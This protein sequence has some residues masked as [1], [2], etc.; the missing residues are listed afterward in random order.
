MA[1]LTSANSVL[2]LGVQNLFNT[3]VQIQGFAADDAFLTQDVETSEVLMGI[4]GQMSYGYVPYITMFEITLQA[5]SASNAFFDAILNA[6]RFM[7]DDLQINGSLRLP[8]L[9]FDYSMTNGVLQKA[10]VVPP[11]KKILQPRKF[12]LA[13][14]SIIGAPV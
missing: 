4:D 13:F 14:Q 11:G 6:Q 12:E 5:N 1:T 7:R 3:P 8:S 9:G 2:S 10:T